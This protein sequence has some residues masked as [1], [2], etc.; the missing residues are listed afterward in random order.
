[1][2]KAIKVAVSSSVLAVASMA[3]FGVSAKSSLQAADSL[4]KQVLAISILNSIDHDFPYDITQPEC[5]DS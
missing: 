1:M 2:S 5:S 4:E 3:P